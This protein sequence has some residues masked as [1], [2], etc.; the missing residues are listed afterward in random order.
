MS[1]TEMI[2]NVKQENKH[3]KQTKS[4]KPITAKHTKL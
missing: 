4:N 3:E 2:P 1:Y